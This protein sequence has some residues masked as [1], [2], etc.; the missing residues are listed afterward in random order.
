[1]EDQVYAYHS[2]SE[3]RHWWFVSRRRILAPLID[4]CMKDHPGGLVV[5]VGCGT[6]GT[7]AWLSSRYA[8]VGIDSSEQ[9]IAMARRKYPQGNFHC[10]ALE[11]KLP[12]LAPQ[13]ALYMLMD[14]LEHILDDRGFL[15]QIVAVMRPGARLLITVPADL[16]L[17]SEHDDAA[18]HLRRY[19]APGLAALWRDL[20]VKLLAATPFNARL[21]PFIRTA[22]LIGRRLGIFTGKGGCDL[23][24]PPWPLNDLLTM[25]FSGERDR[26]SA[27]LDKPGGKPFRHGTSLLALLERI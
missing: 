21:Y 17:W 7:V 26:V 8:C 13:T 14:V 18:N 15:T 16:A 3:D 2:Q 9:A 10:G 27:L 20:P 24:T 19:D 12:S 1:M 23:A 6:G 25:I 4:A 22:R 5:D 11:N